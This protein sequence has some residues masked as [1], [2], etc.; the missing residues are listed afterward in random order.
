MDSVNSV[1]LKCRLSNHYRFIVG[2]ICLHLSYGDCLSYQIQMAPFF[3]NISS[4]LFYCFYVRIFFKF[5]LGLWILRPSVSVSV[6]LFN[7][8]STFVGFL[9]LRVFG[10]LS[11]S[12]LLFPRRFGQYILRPSSGVYRTRE[13]SQNF[14][15]RPLLNPRGSLVL[16]PFAITG[17]KC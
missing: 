8:I 1:I 17:Y 14:E 2:Y 7:G 3:S 6:T 13:P 10:L 15:L 12:L 5:F 4:G 9:S 11:P 16:I